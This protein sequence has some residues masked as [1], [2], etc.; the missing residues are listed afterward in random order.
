MSQSEPALAT[1]GAIADRCGKKVHQVAWVVRKLHLKPRG[2]AGRLR[3]FGDKDV[4]TIIA[5]LTRTERH[6]QSS[7][8]NPSTH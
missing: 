1:L 4:E 3:V 2:R 7:A 8:A 5:E 6:S